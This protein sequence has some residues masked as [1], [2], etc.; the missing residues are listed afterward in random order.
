MSGDGTTYVGREN[1]EVMDAAVNY[2]RWLVHG[3]RS[4]ASALVPSPCW[5]SA[6]ARER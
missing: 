1:P 4:K 5:I 6:L 3:S 2:N